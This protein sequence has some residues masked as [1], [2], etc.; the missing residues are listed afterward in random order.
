MV[1]E[2]AEQK[3]SLEHVA[4]AADGWQVIL[5]RPDIAVLI[6]EAEGEIIGYASTI[7]HFHLWSGGDVLALDDLNLRPSHRSKGVGSQLMST[8]ARLAA[9]DDLPVLWGVRLNNHSAQR[10]YTRLGANLR[11]KMTATWAPG[12]YRCHPDRGSACGQGASHTNARAADYLHRVPAIKGADMIGAWLQCRSRSY[13]CPGGGTTKRGEVG[14]MN[15]QRWSTRS[16][17]NGSS[18]WTGT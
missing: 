8:V 7:G 12:A 6:A 3:E 4:I 5:A 10:F 14:W 17:T 18:R 9:R 16:V 1:R 11:T 15:C 2:F 13:R